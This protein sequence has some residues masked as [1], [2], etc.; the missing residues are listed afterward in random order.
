MR[1]DLQV[2]LTGSIV[3]CPSSVYVLFY[4]NWKIGVPVIDEYKIINHHRISQATRVYFLPFCFTLS[5]GHLL[6]T[7]L[8]IDISTCTM[9]YE[10]NEYLEV[11][12]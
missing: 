12:K 4:I 6:G 7:V 2:L 3:L 11:L 5:C 8:I 1:D 10:D 9:T